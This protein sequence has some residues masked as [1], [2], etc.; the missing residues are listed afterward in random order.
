MLKDIRF[1]SDNRK[2]DSGKSVLRREK[3]ENAKLKRER[4]QTL[5]CKKTKF[6]DF[7]NFQNFASKIKRWQ[8]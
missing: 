4:Q 1:N 3:T 5:L 2:A 8:Y 6:K 7:Q